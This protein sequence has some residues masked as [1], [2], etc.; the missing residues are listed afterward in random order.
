MKEGKIR[1]ELTTIA[2]MS[3][4]PGQHLLSPIIPRVFLSSIR[5]RASAWLDLSIALEM[6]DP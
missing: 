5:S 4:I 1:H 2:I 3:L 6:S